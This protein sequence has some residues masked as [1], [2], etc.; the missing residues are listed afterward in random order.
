MLDRLLQSLLWLSVMGLIMVCGG[1]SVFCGYNALLRL[2]SRH[3]DEACPSL[4]I[5][6]GFVIATWM[7]CRHADE[8]MDRT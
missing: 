5:G 8:L 4:L 6:V 3:L 2:L 1:A 7:L